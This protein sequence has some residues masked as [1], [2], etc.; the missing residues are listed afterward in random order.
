MKKVLLSV[1]AMSSV[2]LAKAQ[3]IRIENKSCQDIEVSI[4]GNCT[5][6]GSN[7]YYISANNAISLSFYPGGQFP[8]VSWVNN[9]TPPPN[10]NFISSKIYD[11]VVLGGNWGNGVDYNNTAFH[12]NAACGI[13]SATSSGWLTNTTYIVVQ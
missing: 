7:P 8:V 2:Y 11:P 1:L 6:C 12:L 3:D 4:Q 5:S 13:I 10:S 9:Y